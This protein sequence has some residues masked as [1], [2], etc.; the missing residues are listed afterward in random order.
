M[1]HGRSVGAYLMRASRARAKGHPCKALADTGYFGKISDRAH[2]IRVALF[3]RK[4]TFTAISAARL[5]SGA[6]IVPCD[7][8]GTP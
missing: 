4:H 6:V 5:A 8:R 3:D 1:T 2:G 7:G